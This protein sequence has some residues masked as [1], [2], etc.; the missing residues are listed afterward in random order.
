MR[1]VLDAGKTRVERERASTL[2]RLSFGSLGPP[3]QAQ[4]EK[5]GQ[6]R[7]YPGGQD[8]RYATRGFRA[9]FDRGAEAF[10]CA[11]RLESQ[12]SNGRD[13]EYEAGVFAQVFRDSLCIAGDGA[14]EF[15]TSGDRQSSGFV[16]V[17]CEH[18]DVRAG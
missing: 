10:G 15:G 8:F 3:P 6:H 5:Q 17:A 14:G 12:G 16:C 2:R 18:G 9:G 13:G 4:A 7:R 11:I 1:V